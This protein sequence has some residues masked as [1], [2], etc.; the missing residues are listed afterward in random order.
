MVASCFNMVARRFIIDLYGSQPYC[1][2][3]SLNEFEIC[4]YLVLYRYKN[5]DSI[6]LN[7][8]IYKTAGY[9]ATLLNL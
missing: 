7:L 5:I 8:L 1:I 4:K 9:L 2:I 6:Y 3:I